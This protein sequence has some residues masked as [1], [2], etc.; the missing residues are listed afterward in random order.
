MIQLYIYIYT[1][2]H[3]LFHILFQHGLSQDIEYTSLC[4]MV[5]LRRL[6]LEIFL[7]VNLFILFIYFWLR[8]VF[9]AARG[10]SLV[11]PWHVGSSWTRARTRVPCI[12]RQI[13]NHCATREA[14]SLE[15]FLSKIS[16]NG[17]LPWCPVVKTP[18]SQCRGPGFDIR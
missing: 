15:I 4:Y 10:L 13:L 14:P 6:S 18:R 8:W 17:G 2:T 3:I 5:G 9:F 1:H 11:A 12:G 16:P 7:K